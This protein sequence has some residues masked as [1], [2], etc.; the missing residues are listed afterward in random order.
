MRPI[1]LKIK[2][3]NS[4]M[5]EQE[6]DFRRLTSM[7]LFGIFGQTGSGKSSILDGI[8]LSLYG[9]ISRGN[10]EFLNKNMDLLKVSFEFSLSGEKNQTFRVERE[11][12]RNSSGDIRTSY[13]RILEIDG[14]EETILEDKVSAVNKR[15]EEIIGLSS[16]DFSRTV[17]LPQGKFSEF[18]KLQNGPRRE[19]LERIFNL[20]AFGAEL[21][22]KVSKRASVYKTKHSEINGQL[23]GYEFLSEDYVKE[24]REALQQASTDVDAGVQALEQLQKSYD[25]AKVIWQIQQQKIQLEESFAKHLEGEE[26]I[27]WKAKDLQ[28]ADLAQSISPYWIALEKTTAALEVSREQ[29]GLA[30]T[31]A[32]QMMVLKTEAKTKLDQIKE[33]RDQQ[34]P[35]LKVKESQLAEADQ[36][37]Q[38]LLSDEAEVIKLEQSLGSLTEV[39]EREKAQLIKRQANYQQKLTQ[40]EGLEAKI[41]SLN[42]PESYKSQV[43]AAAELKKNSHALKQ[44]TEKKQGQYLELKARYEA[45]KEQKL[46]L[47][48]E[49]GINQNE[50][51]HLL[52]KFNDLSAAVPGT[53]DQLILKTKAL[54][55]LKNQWTQYEQFSKDLAL[56]AQEQQSHQTQLK[57]CQVDRGFIQEKLESTR[58]ALEIAERSKIAQTLRETLTPGSPCPVCGSVDHGIVV[59]ASV[60]LNR[61]GLGASGEGTDSGSRDEV[62]QFHRLKD[63]KKELETTLQKLNQEIAVLESKFA[64]AESL[65]LKI[66][67]QLENLGTTFLET[68]PEDAKASLEAFE[69][70]LQQYEAAKNNL[71]L[72]KRTLEQKK[73][74]TERRQAVNA[75]EL[76]M[77]SAQMVSAEAELEEHQSRLYVL[78]EA[79]KREI[80]DL[81]PDEIEVLLLDMDQKA[82]AV[83]EFS[84]TLRAIKTS[85]K[86]DLAAIETYT[87][88]VQDSENNA[89]SMAVALRTKKETCEMLR[90]QMTDKFGPL[91][92]AAEKLVSLKNQ[93][94]ALEESYKQAEEAHSG[95]EKAFIQVNEQL[96]SLRTAF[97]M[98]SVQA[99]EQRQG[100]AMKL[101]E[102]DFPDLETAKKHLWDLEIRESVRGL[103]VAFQSK[104]DQLKGALEAASAQL[105]GRSLSPENWEE[106]NNEHKAL[107]ERVAA[108]KLNHGTLDHELKRLEEQLIELGTILKEK[109]VVEKMLGQLADLSK[110]F[111]ARKFVAF[112]A[113]SQLQYISGKASEQLMAITSG[114]YALEADLEGN[115]LIRDYK[116]GGVTREA[117]TLSGGETFLVSLSLALALSAQIQ[118]KG[119]APLELFFL[120]EGFGTLDDDTLEVVMNALENLHHDKLSIGLI[121]HVESIKNRVPIKLLVSPAKSGLGGSR[122]K[123]ELS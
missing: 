81:N 10:G 27:Q 122:V 15:C 55:Q 13:A 119:R 23:M 57:K 79:F 8:T 93:I 49:K 107:S 21:S 94:K 113:S 1:S 115:F 82:K 32:D 40:A 101:S 20:E 26:E 4:F 104:K 97:E 76:E 30:S 68:S 73:S 39:L 88:Q 121:S 85:F 120:D 71:E 108:L 60:D 16:E 75:N 44:T 67:G 22:M 89:V 69:A 98:Q 95:V 92:L 111:E 46:Q 52:E 84:G 14:D 18:L 28:L 116:N 96:A 123:I 90:I 64:A 54:E 109:A 62:E 114:N 36:E 43:R 37:I 2:G 56:Y 31:K 51:A 103:I 91:D 78:E 70:S 34:L 83:E 33:E 25:Q 87:K 80:G 12:K 100:L 86:A 58:E 7:G 66:K 59:G 47:D 24:K 61:E 102:V 5:E 77:F 29:V 45:C 9:K 50:M 63:T 38:K 106:I 41:E 112:I 118:L 72:L 117:S 35:L 53:G 42:L 17:V 3:L 48:Q 99:T 74:D 110:L 11:M 65:H 105:A 19:M 6:I